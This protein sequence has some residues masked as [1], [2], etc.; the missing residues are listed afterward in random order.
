MDYIRIFTSA[1]NKLWEKKTKIRIYI[2][3]YDCKSILLLNLN[4]DNRH[5]EF[6]VRLQKAVRDDPRY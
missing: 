2:Y 6:V 5:F 1:S 4:L 3:I